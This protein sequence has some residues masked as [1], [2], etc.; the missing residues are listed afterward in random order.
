MRIC[1][2]LLVILVE[3]AQVNASVIFDQTENNLFLK[4]C[5]RFENYKLFQDTSKFE[6]IKIY[7]FPNYPE[8][9]LLS[10]PDDPFIF[11]YTHRIEEKQSLKLRK[12][13]A[14]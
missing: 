8:G 14:V 7:S 2:L 6:T 1:I 4:F 5:M 3:S 9:K 10:S 13:F 12:Q 11:Y